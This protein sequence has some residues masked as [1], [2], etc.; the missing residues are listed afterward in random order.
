MQLKV[1]ENKRLKLFIESSVEKHL[2]DKRRLFHVA[3]L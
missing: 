1:K 2:I 3:A